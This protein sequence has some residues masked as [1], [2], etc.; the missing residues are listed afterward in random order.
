[1]SDSESSSLEDRVLA[2]VF[3]LLLFAVLGLVFASFVGCD[4]L[5]GTL[6]GAGIGAVVGFA[7]GYEG[8]AF[9]TWFWP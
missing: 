4:L 5:A 1:M 2:S 8:L 9:L 3:G 6:W 7:L